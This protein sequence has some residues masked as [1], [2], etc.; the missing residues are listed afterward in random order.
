MLFFGLL[1]IRIKYKIHLADIHYCHF[2]FLNG[3]YGDGVQTGLAKVEV[4]DVSL[5]EVLEM[6]SIFYDEFQRLVC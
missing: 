5:L 3:A 4:T 1:V 2:C 6:T